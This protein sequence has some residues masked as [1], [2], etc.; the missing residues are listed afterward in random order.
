MF[1][2]VGEYLNGFVTRSVRDKI[3]LNV[4]SSVFEKYFMGVK[5]KDED[6][7]NTII[8]SKGIRFVDVLACYE[9]C[10]E[11]C[12]DLKFSN[13]KLSLYNV[14]THLWYVCKVMGV[15]LLEDDRE[16]FSNALIYYIELK[17]T[18]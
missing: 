8:T 13:V 9:Y 7:E 10:E 6:I 2:S 17:G 12:S 1:L 18:R 15:E 16:L 5:V 4:L 3:D 14:Y 11:Y